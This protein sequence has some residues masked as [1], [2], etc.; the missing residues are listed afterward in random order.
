[1]KVAFLF[2]GQGAQH[3]G[4]GK[5]VYDSVSAAPEYFDR[6]EKATNLEL[7]KLCFEG[8][9]EQLN[10]TDISQPAIFTVSVAMLASLREALGEENYL[11]IQPTHTAGLS[12]GEYTAL[13][14][15]GAMDFETGVK[16]VAKRG[17]L[18]QNAAT[19]TES[20]MVS[21]IGLDEEK[22]LELC[23]KASQ[24]EVLSCAN[25]NCPGQIVLSGQKAAC[26][27]AAEMASDLG[28]RMAVPLKV[29]GAFH[30]ELMQPAADEFATVLD[31]V[32]FKD[33]QL[34]VIA[35]NDATE[36][37]NAGEIKQR[38]LEQLTSPV[39][40][41]QSVKA[42]IDDGVEKYFEIGPGKVLAGLMR[43]IQRR[44]DFTSVNSLKSLQ[45][46][47]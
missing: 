6:A 43:R 41:E 13:Y 5:D 47:G 12:L 29:A 25:F 35:N 17:Q 30:S 18:M 19:R 39:R 7:K 34:H 23:E 28:A 38:L 15:A 14:A 4:M 22:C 36:Y 27:R 11:N 10:R 46:L 32:D 8:P 31:E 9:E 45:S 3:V 26:E 40:W 42:L 21:V 2:P 1:M 33:P 24:G 20:G 44:A 37:R 16:L